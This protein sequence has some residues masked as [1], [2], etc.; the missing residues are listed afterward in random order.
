MFQKGWK[1]AF[2]DKVF[3]V[4]Q[5]PCRTGGTYVRAIQ[6]ARFHADAVNLVVCMAA[7]GK[8]ADIVPAGVVF[9]HD[10]RNDCVA[11]QVVVFRAK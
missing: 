2:Y 6:E 10:V 1:F 9:Q 3:E 8:L 7:D 4:V 11:K 5:E